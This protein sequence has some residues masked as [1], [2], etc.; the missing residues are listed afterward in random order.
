MSQ[1]GGWFISSSWQE[2]PCKL[3][4]ALTAWSHLHSQPD[5]LSPPT[6]STHDQYKHY[7]GNDVTMV[8]INITTVMIITNISAVM[9][10][11]LT[12]ML[13]GWVQA[14]SC[15]CDPSSAH[16]MIGKCNFFHKMHRCVNND[17]C[18]STEVHK[19][20][21][22][23]NIHQLCL[24][25]FAATHS[26][27]SK[28]SFPDSYTVL[29]C[30]CADPLASASAQDSISISTSTRQRVIHKDSTS[31][32]GRLCCASHHNIAHADS[33]CFSLWVPEQM[34]LGPHGL[35]ADQL[36][37]PTLLCKHLVLQQALVI[38]CFAI[39]S[40]SSLLLIDGLITWL[41][42]KQLYAKRKAS[43]ES[44]SPLTPVYSQ[45][46]AYSKCNQVHSCMCSH[47]D[48]HRKMVWHLRLQCA[49][50][51]IRNHMPM[52]IVNTSQ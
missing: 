2:E 24:W 48:K 27:V 32:A 42:C 19:S 28:L 15:L 21:A 33:A 20:Y 1:T 35:Y 23:Q 12:S 22:S 8:I 47:L 34:L 25:Q 41:C 26:R 17:R 4:E 45:Q 29:C 37:K 43:S 14:K 39:A 11:V 40:T 9:M 50:M 10:A 49:F 5:L 18:Q 51:T 46:H 6:C 3:L 36:L 13:D 31:F 52:A 38:C 16:A 44:C 7:D 30:T